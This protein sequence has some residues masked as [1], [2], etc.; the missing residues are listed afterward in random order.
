MHK[1]LQKRRSSVSS[2]TLPPELDGNRTNWFDF[3]GN[4]REIGRVLRGQDPWGHP[5]GNGNGLGGEGGSGRKWGWKPRFNVNPFGRRSRNGFSRLPRSA[6]EEAMM[7]DGEDRFS[8][9]DE[10]DEHAGNGHANGNI[11]DG[12]YAEE[13]AA[14]G[15]QRTRGM[16]GSGVIRL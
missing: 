3:A 14:W 11:S 12:A 4:A 7:R 10:D 5:N 9:D 15:A 1:L 16:D 6:E 13:S 8:I 2:S